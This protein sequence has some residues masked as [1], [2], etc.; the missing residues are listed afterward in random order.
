M[1]VKKGNFRLEFIACHESEETR[2]SILSLK[3]SVFEMSKEIESFFE[4]IINVKGSP[5]SELLESIRPRI[6]LVITLSNES[7]EKAQDFKAVLEKS[8][9]ERPGLIIE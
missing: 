4:T 2:K 6:N 7:Y 1:L 9:S 5:D 3:E 8:A